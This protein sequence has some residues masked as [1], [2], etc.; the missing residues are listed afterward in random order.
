M[1]SVGRSVTIQDVANDSG[2]SVATVSR[3]L[4][5][6]PNVAP[7]TRERVQESAERLDYHPDPAAA[8]LASG[9]SRTVAMA[10]P[11]LDSWYFTQ[12]MAGVEAVL[13]A[14]GYDLLVF[15]IDSDSARRRMTQGPLVKRA[16]GLI[17]VNIKLSADESA[18]LASAGVKVVSVGAASD[19]FSSVRVD[20]E[21]VAE[22]AVEHLMSLGHRRIG[23]AGHGDDPM[24]FDVPLD[25]RSGYRNVLERAGLT[26][27]E[28][29]ERGAGFSVAGGSEAAAH[30]LDLDDPP[31]AIFAMSDETAFGVMRAVWDRGLRV[32]E[33]VSVVGVDDHEFSAVVGLTTIRQDVTEHGSVAARLL[34][35]RFVDPAIEA[36]KYAVPI[37]LIER[38]TTSAPAVIRH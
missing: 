34:L 20:D 26:V 19:S 32:P 3:A 22:L 11:S 21:R 36:T 10:V 28:E 9:R 4:R 13:T 24:K 16:D 18:A 7:S 33:D 15:A 30:L 23:L 27:D 14:A 5:G 29:L 37:A 31:T 2:V 1:T 25:R 8:R 35:D 12:V 17:I 38:K 6:L